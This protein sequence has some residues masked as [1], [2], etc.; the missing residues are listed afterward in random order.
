MAQMIP[1]FLAEEE[2]SS[3]MARQ[4]VFRDLNDPLDCYDDMELVR[5]FRF[6]RVSISKITELVTNYLNFTERSYAASPHLQVCVALRFFASGTFQII[7]GD[8][9]NVSQASASRYIRDVSLGCVLGLVDGTHIRIQRPSENEADYI[10]RHFYHSI[11]VQAICQP[12]GMF[13]DVL[14]CFPGSVHDSRIWT[15]SGVGMHVENTF[16]I[17]E[18][19]LGDSGYMM[20]PYLLTPYRQPISTPQSNYNYA[21]KRTRVIVEQTFGRWKRRFHCLHGALRM[22]PDKVC[23]S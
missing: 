20:R 7:C 16:S 14:A 17:G 19:I 4:R 22:S 23:P 9:I 11:N 18:H 12:D 2:T 8:G 6:S 10:N 13:S 21:H 5:R 1:L 15:I 3:L